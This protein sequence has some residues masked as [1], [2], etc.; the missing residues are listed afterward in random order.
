[1]SVLVFEEEPTTTVVAESDATLLVFEDEQ[2]RGVVSSP[3]AEADFLVFDQPTVVT[4]TV[5]PA[6]FVIVE[7]PNPPIVAL[8][9]AEPDF[10]VI[11]SDGPPGPPGPTGD[12]G[13]VGPPGA[14]GAQGPEG[15]IGAPG[16]PGTEYYGEFQFA[17]PSSTWLIT[18]NRA[19]YGLSVETFDMNGELWEGAVRYLDPNTIEVDWYYPMSGLARVFS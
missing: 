5:L 8:L 12:L 10:L 14:T 7:T 4:E 2:P 11:T 19:T 6:D 1:M 9:D 18:H 16:V 13:P 17:S 3:E 15:P